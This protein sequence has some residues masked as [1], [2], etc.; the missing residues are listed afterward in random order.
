[1]M[2]VDMM[3]QLTQLISSVGFP[4]VAC[5][6]L[7]KQNCNIIENHKSEIDTLKEMINTNTLSVTKMYEKLDSLIEVLG[8]RDK[9]ED[10]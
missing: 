8:R 3:N 5:V 7:Y 1:M 4:I 6:F 2:E 9:N 10:K